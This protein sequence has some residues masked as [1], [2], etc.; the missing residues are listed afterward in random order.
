MFNSINIEKIVKNEDYF[1]LWFD[2]IYAPIWIR[3]YKNMIIYLK[4]Y[5]KY[6]FKY[7]KIEI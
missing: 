7:N 5:K 3:F 4:L 2:Y 1:L 6:K